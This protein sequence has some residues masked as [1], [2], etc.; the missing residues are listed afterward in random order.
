[1]HFEAP[2]SL[3]V[4]QRFVRQ[5]GQHR[6]AGAG[7][8]LGCFAVEAPV[9]DGQTSH[10]VS[11]LNREVLTGLVEDSPQAPVTFGHIL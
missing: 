4:Q 7:Y 6:Q 5:A 3:M 8:L 10:H 9:K 1:M 2:R 11:L